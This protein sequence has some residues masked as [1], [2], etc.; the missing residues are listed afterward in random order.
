MFIVRYDATKGQPSLRLHTDSSHV[1]FNILLNDDFEGGGTRFH[2]R[3]LDTYADA[4]LTPGDVL[5]NNANILHEGLATTNGTRYIFVGF[6]AVETFDPFTERDND[7]SLFASWFS[8]TWMQVR[9]KQ[10]F[11]NRGIRDGSLTRSSDHVPSQTWMDSSYVHNLFLDIWVY[12]TIFQ[13]VWA[14]HGIVN[15]VEDPDNREKFIA[16]LDA[17]S[18]YTGKEASWFKGKNF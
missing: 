16:A 13:D 11:E 8:L 18:S 17:D 12:F 6:T 2:N 9:F 14:P 15:L 1:S 10:G 7:L 3:H 4:H 5:I